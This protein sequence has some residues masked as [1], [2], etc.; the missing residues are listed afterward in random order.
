MSFAA[1]NSSH[2][3]KS[4]G[5]KLFFCENKWKTNVFKRVIYF[6]D[7][8]CLEMLCGPEV[9]IISDEYQCECDLQRGHGFVS[10]SDPCRLLT[11]MFFSSFFKI[12]I[13]VQVFIPPTQKS[14]E[15][16]R[17]L[18]LWGRAAGRLVGAPWWRRWS[19]GGSR[20]SGDL[21][22]PSPGPGQTSHFCL[23][24]RAERGLSHSPDPPANRTQQEVS[25]N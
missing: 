1:L 18:S 24:R 23:Y 17:V 20:P 12:Q 2:P 11:S 8:S 21:L 10:L 25:Q 15:W 16:V 19:L 9:Q 6:F 4:W 22:P 14:P 3:M 5:Q 7:L 13:L